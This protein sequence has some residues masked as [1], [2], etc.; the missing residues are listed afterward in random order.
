VLAGH[1]TTGLS[2]VGFPGFDRGLFGGQG[3]CMTSR[4][5]GFI[6]SDWFWF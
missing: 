3:L 5:V 4:D 6:V 1:R 2:E